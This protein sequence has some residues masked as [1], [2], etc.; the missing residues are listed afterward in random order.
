MSPT[1]STNCGSLENLKFSTRCGCN[2]KACQIR[3]MAV[4]DSPVFPA[5]SR[6]LQWV[7][8]SGIDSSVWVMTSSTSA[9]GNQSRGARSRFVQQPFQPTHPKAFPPLTRRR[10]RD[11]QLLCDHSVAPSLLTSE[12]NPGAHRERLGRLWAAC[13]HRQFLFLLWRYV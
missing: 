9:F 10:S 2:P 4:C 13:Q 1:F 5:I 12:H 7:L 11:V 6:L 3:T 8:L